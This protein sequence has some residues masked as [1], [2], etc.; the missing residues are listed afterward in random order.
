MYSFSKTTVCYYLAICWALYCDL[1]TILTKKTGFLPLGN[2][3][4]RKKYLKIKGK[5]ILVDVITRMV[6]LMQIPNVYSKGQT[7]PN[8]TVWS[9]NVGLFWGQARIMGNSS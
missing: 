2:I 1:G 7:N 4:W 8:V 5:R 9:R 6:L 3:I